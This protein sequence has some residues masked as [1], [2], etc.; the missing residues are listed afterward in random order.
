ML[1]DV[2]INIDEILKEVDLDHKKNDKVLNLSGGQKRKLCIAI[3][4]IGN[5][6][7]IFLDE[8][9]TGLDPLSR[10]KVWDLLLNKKKGRVIFLTTHYMDEADILSDRKLILSHGKI[11]CLGTSVYLKNHF[12]MEYSLDIESHSCDQVDQIIKKYVPEGKYII[13]VEKQQRNT[14]IEMRT[15]KLPFSSTSQFSSMFNEIEYYTGEGNLIKNYALTMPTLEEL[16]IRLEDSEEVTNDNDNNDAFIID[17]HEKLPKLE[18]VK[19]LSNISK[20]FSLIKFRYKIFFHNKTF[21]GN[22]ILTPI[23]VTIITFFIIKLIGNVQIKTF[24]SKEINPNIYNG[25]IWNIDSSQTNIPNFKDL[26]GSIV[27]INSIKEISNKELNEI[28]KT[29]DKEPY[30]V[31]SVSGSL[32]NNIYNF[33]V[34]FNESMN[35]ALPAT[36]N[37]LSNTILASNN[38]NERIVTKS[39]PFSYGNYTFVTVVSLLVGIYI[40]AALISGISLYGPLVVRERV[41]QLLQQLQLNGVSRINYWLSSLLTDGSLALITCASVII[42]GMIFQSDTFLDVHVLVILIVSIVIW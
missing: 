22:A 11:R 28:G 5:P 24:N 14:D 20:I 23:I 41:N 39:Y 12:N 27:G 6:K 18:S 16:F 9:T 36:M 34:Y 32:E 25:S 38:V 26:Y 10:R 13:D 17:T 33:N 35:H 7:Y 29:V 40:G 8:P 2:D 42:V 30:Y 1:K 21:A 3:A 37:A 15:W 31:S 19:S 4:T